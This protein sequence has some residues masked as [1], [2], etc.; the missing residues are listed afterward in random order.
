MLYQ[1]LCDEFLLLDTRLEEYKLY[2][3]KVKLA[4]NKVGEFSFSIY[5]S[6]PYFDK[7]KKMKSMITVYQNEKIIFKG[8]ILDFEQGFYNEK[9]VICESELAFL[10]DSIQR[11]YSFTGTISDFL[12]MLIE[13]HNGQV[14]T[15]KQFVLGNVTVTDSNNYI[16]RSD[17]EYST[18]WDLINSSLI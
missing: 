13:N 8:R 12:Q 17:S 6:H 11:P 1:V 10:I 2:N 14:G 7:L 3:P 16:N 9:Q 4:L 5:P 15:D 18:T